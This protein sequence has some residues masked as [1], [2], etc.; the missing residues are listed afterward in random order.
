MS[1]ITKNEEMVKIGFER[2]LEQGPMAYALMLRAGYT[3]KQEINYVFTV[4]R[5]ALEILRSN[6]LSYNELKVAKR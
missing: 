1:V 6:G 4:S 2:P 3:V 5:S